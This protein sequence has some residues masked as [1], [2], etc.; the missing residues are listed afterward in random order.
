LASNAQLRDQIRHRE[1]AETQLRQ[2]QKM[3][4][5]G[6]LTGGV[7]HDF[8]NMLSVVMGEIE[9]VSR[10]ISNGDFAV[11]R[12][13]DAATEGTRRTAMLTQRLLAFAPAD[14]RQQDDR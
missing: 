8:N 14:R 1:L 4:A 11:Q 10:R 6:Q 13:L 3:E 2:A 9:L 7:A 12:F 5:I